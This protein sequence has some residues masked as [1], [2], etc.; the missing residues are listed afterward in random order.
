MEACFRC[1]WCG[2]TFGPFDDKAEMGE[3]VESPDKDVPDS[4]LLHAEPC[5]IEAEKKGWVYA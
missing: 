4:V 3:P 5:S 1:A 2:E